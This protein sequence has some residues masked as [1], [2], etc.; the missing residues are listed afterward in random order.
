MLTYV[1]SDSGEKSDTLHFENSHFKGNVLIDYNRFSVIHLVDCKIDGHLLIDNCK[2]DII[3]TG[4]IIS[5]SIIINYLKNGNSLHFDKLN[6]PI[7]AENNIYRV[8][9]LTE[10]REYNYANIWNSVDNEYQLQFSGEENNTLQKIKFVYDSKEQTA[11]PN[12]LLLFNSQIKLNLDASTWSGDVYILDSTITSGTLDMSNASF[13]NK[14][15]PSEGK[16]KPNTFMVISTGINSD[17]EAKHAQFYG[18]VI[19]QDVRFDNEIYF[20]GSCFNQ[21]VE[22]IDCTM[23]QECY[24]EGATFNNNILMSDTIFQGKASFKKI[25]WANEN[26]FLKME[27]GC[28][29]Y[30]HV[31]MSGENLE[32]YL[33]KNVRGLRNIFYSLLT[34]NADD[35]LQFLKAWS[36]KCIASDEQEKVPPIIKLVTKIE[37]GIHHFTVICKNLP[38]LF[39]TKNQRD[40]IHGLMQPNFDSHE[41]KY[42]ETNLI[43]VEI[44]MYIEARR[45]MEDMANEDLISECHILEMEAQRRKA[46]IHFIKWFRFTFLKYTT[47]Y[48]ESPFRIFGFITFDWLFFTLIYWLTIKIHEVTGNPYPYNHDKN[49]KRS[50]IESMYHSAD[51]LLSLNLGIDNSCCIYT[52]IITLLQGFINIMIIALM[53][54]VVFRKLDLR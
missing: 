24:F 19:F 50:H 27:N 16:E 53:T 18:E 42:T 39:K 30:G 45:A 46:S 35:P 10:F 54:Q 23:Y 2:S 32:N 34:N 28:G 22:F 4:S 3:L 8:V 12:S 31:D 1:I 41:L 29:F 52:V 7:R 13:G 14:V 43:D 20:S 33:F 15:D 49:L 51:N 21:K 47:N 36:K 48:G 5:G 26:S 11:S 9:S 6:N 25:N 40:K 44:E 17:L 38:R 37:S